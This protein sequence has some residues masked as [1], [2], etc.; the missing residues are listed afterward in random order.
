MS[1]VTESLRAG[2]QCQKKGLAVGLRAQVRDESGGGRTW[3]HDEDECP[4]PLAENRAEG[5][6][7][8]IQDRIRSQSGARM[9]G[10][11]LEIQAYSCAATAT[12]VR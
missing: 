5:Y 7:G 4:R 9:L 2:G 3:S 6:R 11:A 10:G 1:E 8:P 12:A